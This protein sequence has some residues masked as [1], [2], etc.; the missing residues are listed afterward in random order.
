MK[1]ILIGILILVIGFTGY[2]FFFGKL[3]PYSSVIFG[4]EKHELTNTIIYTQK[5]VSF[6]DYEKI[7]T[8]IP[9]VEKFHD[10]R[11]LRKPKL[12]LY[13][14]SISYLRHSPSRARFCT[15]YNGRIFLTPWALKEARNGKIS[16]E[17]YLAHELSHSLLHQHS[18]LINAIKYP[19]W[20]L[21]GTAV[22]SSNQMGTSFYPG[23]NETYRLIQSG[24]FMPP[25]YYKTKNEDKINLDLEN[26]IP[27][28]YSEFACIVDYLISKYG[29]QEFLTYIKAI[30][31]GNNH[32]KIFRQVFEINFDEFLI[33]F[34]DYVL[35][36]GKTEA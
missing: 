17:I 18:G 25:H 3:F 21:E 14:D 31:K 7:D 36:D 32:N 1:K 16:L 33:D 19:E 5:G 28:M 9:G 12:F 6:N 34:K 11:Y 15:F 30:T 2:L 20:L 35:N 26:R 27:F 29:K 23:K 8:L 13:Y 10:L 24:N 4:F 22:Y